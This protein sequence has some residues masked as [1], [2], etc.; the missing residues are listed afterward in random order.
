MK[1]KWSLIAAVAAGAALGAC[2]RDVVAVP[3]ANAQA[4]G[5]Q[6]VVVGASIGP[7]GY[8]EDL[9]KYTRDGW[10]YVGTIPTQGNSH[11]VFAR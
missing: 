6:Y 8:E 7:S 10:Q 3:R 1:T 11:L 5:R 4:F 9:N 2:F